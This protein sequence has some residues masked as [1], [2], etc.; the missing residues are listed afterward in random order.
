MLTRLTFRQLE[1]CLA[2][3]EFGSIA[4]AAEHIHISPSSI[5]AAITQVE[6]ELSVTLFVRRHAQGLSLTPAGVEVLKQI[7]LT[8]DQA[9]HLYDIAH[10]AQHGI[11]G[12]LRVGCFT[13]LAA[14]VAPELCQGFAEA[15]PGV[16][17]SQCEDHH[18]GLMER[19]H[20]AQIDVAITYDL[21]VAETGVSFEALASLP[22]FVIVGEANPLAKKAAVTLKELAKRP[23][24]LLDLPLSREYFLSLFH[25]AGVRP[26]VAARSSSPDV[27]RSLVANGVGY[28]LANVRPR[29]PHSLDGKRI[30]NVPLK[31]RHRPMKLGLA[32]IKDQQPRRV[33]ETFMERCRSCMADGYIPGMAAEGAG[34]APSRKT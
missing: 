23:M 8:L 13:P 19:L 22:P 6:N 28:S 20:N 14:M 11:R 33:V 3:G 34:P 24:I 17:I 7:R 2:A 25:E 12:P 32:W 16:E 29:A 31:G 27:L 9:L 4:K 10:N 5:S 30:I 21:S 15:Y 18:E 26:T 1:Y